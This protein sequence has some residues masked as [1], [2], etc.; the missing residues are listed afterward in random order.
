MVV[1]APVETVVGR[2]LGRVWLQSHC[3]GRFSDRAMKNSW[4]SRPV[5]QRATKA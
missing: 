3:G 5:R 4:A 1:R 2:Q